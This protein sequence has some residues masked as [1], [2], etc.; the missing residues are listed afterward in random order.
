M[1]PQ[2]LAELIL[3][4]ASAKGG[5][6]IAALA[7]P[8]GAGKSTLAET[9]VGLLGPSSR[10]VPMD[11]FHY[12]DAILIARGQRNRKGAPETFDVAGYRHLLSRLREEDEVAIPV[13]DR[14][15]ELSRGSADIVTRDHRILVTEGNY[16]LLNEAPWTELRFDMTVMIEVPEA[17]LD[18]RLLARWDF[19]G[20]TPEEARAWID[21]NDMPNIRRVIHGSREADHRIVWR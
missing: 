18:R 2:A 14:S 13:F 5:R 1:T 21:G 15:L 4:K 6:F 10:V 9:L 7:G 12:D 3:A 11:G 20:K 16:L 8:P 17:E 19:Y